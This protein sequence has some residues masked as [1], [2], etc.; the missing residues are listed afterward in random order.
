MI[1]PEGRYYYYNIIAGEERGVIGL[2]W[3][4]K[5]FIWF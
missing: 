1:T 3:V 2:I 5:C 4:V